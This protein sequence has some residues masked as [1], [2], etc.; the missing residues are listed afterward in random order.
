MPN[1]QL[2]EAMRSHGVKQWEAAEYLDIQ[3]SRFSKLMR[4]ELDPDLMLSALDAVN[5]IAADKVRA[6]ISGAEPI[7]VN[8]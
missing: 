6:K 3:E 2:K 8:K 5:Q 7:V 1:T 4:H